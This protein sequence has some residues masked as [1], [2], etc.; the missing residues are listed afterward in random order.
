MRKH[1]CTK[2]TKIENVCIVEKQFLNRHLFVNRHVLPHSISS[3]DRSLFF[4]K[5]LS[6]FG[7][8]EEY[9]TTRY[10]RYT[11]PVINM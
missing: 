4:V 5:M 10:E 8:G 7:S 2:I 1:T 9:T 3:A 6:K 11:M